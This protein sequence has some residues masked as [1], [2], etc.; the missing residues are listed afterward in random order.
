MLEALILCHGKSHKV[1]H[2][3]PMCL[4]SGLN[5]SK[6]DLWTT[7]DIDKDTNPDI[8]HDLTQPFNDIRLLSRF[9]IVTTMCCCYDVF[10]N[11]NGTFVDNA[12]N[13]VINFMKTGGHFV[14]ST[15]D[16]GY[17]N[18]ASR[19][20][21][22]LYKVFK[23]LSNRR[24]LNEC[25]EYTLELTYKNI[26]KQIAKDVVHRYPMLSHVPEYKKYTLLSKW[27]R[28]Y[29]SSKAWDHLIVFKKH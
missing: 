24:M 29:M 9:D 27:N 17:L 11:R 7:L 6:T 28:V 5:L 25:E 8:H 4:T 22:S 21:Q 20:N 15:A 14:F 26:S 10:I 2:N 3:E 18:F 16:C 12:F 1:D 23:H 19:R 13:N